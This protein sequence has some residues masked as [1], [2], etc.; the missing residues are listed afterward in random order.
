MAHAFIQH[1]VY[2][3][4]LTLK[5]NMVCQSFHYYIEFNGEF[6]TTTHFC[7]LFHISSWD[8][9][10]EDC[11]VEEHAYFR[12]WYIFLKFPSIMITNVIPFL[13]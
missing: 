10:V 7:I 6:L 5:N 11:L 13:W 12:N 2:Y 8:K 4:T 9:L 1:N 3:Q